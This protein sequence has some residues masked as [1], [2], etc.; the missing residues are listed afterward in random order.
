MHR[1]KKYFGTFNIRKRMLIRFVDFEI[2]NQKRTVRSNFSDRYYCP[3][4]REVDISTGVL[5]RKRNAKKINHFYFLCIT[6]QFILVIK[7]TF[8]RPVD[9]LSH[10]LKIMTLSLTLVAL[11][12]NIFVT[13][14]F[15]AKGLWDLNVS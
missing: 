6:S 3:S 10:N 1:R 8:D 9:P 12:R 14:F 11:P 13:P 5:I 4:E 15:L 7:R 2:S